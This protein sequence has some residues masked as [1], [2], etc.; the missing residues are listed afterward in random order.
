[1]FGYLHKSGLYDRTLIVLLAD[2][3]ES[4]GE[5]GEDEHS[6]FIYNST[7][8]VPLIFK[9]PHGEGAPRVVR[10]LVGTID[11]APTIFELLHFRD[12][13]SRQFQGTSLASDILGKGA[14]SVRPVYSE[15][16]YP[17]DSLGW[18]EL[19][20]LTTERFKYIQAPH[21]EL[22]DLTKDRQELRNLY[23]ESATLAAALRERLADIERRYSSTDTVP[24]RRRRWGRPCPRKPLRSCDHWVT[25]L[26]WPQSSLPPPGRSL[27][28]RTA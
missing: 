23:G 27:T 20:S 8:H 26:I 4:L 2:H 14:G 1:L 17:R 6:F 16:Y 22:Y 21:P 19:A 11:V 13:L 15:T 3:G 10:R 28:P 24:L 7:L 9:L 18:S 25:L 5:H 12:P